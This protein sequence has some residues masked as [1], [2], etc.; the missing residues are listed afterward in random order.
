MRNF[1]GIPEFFHPVSRSA[2][3]DKLQFAMKT[4]PVSLIL[5]GLLAPLCVNAQSPEGSSP[6]PGRDGPGKRQPHRPFMEAWKKADK[7][8]DG[9]LSRGEFDAMPR[10]QSLPEDKR[11]RLF[12]R[13][14]NNKD[15]KLAHGELSRH[16]R[17]PDG[18][19]PPLRRLA[20]LDADK[21][22]GVS[23]EEF[24]TGPLFQ[25]LPAGRQT[26]IFRRLDT[27]GDGVITPKDKPE[28]PMRPDRGPRPGRGEGPPP[29]GPR[30][31]AS[32]MNPERMLQQLDKDGDGAVTFDEFRAGPQAERLSE[33]EQEDRFEA[34]DRNKDL[35]LTPEDF[36]PPP[37]PGR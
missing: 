6:P 35:K 17:Q 27:D 12:E 8:G 34:L 32:R 9:F 33:D 4:I 5:A 22:G 36:P 1:R 11:Q 21:S 2:G 16:D 30:P 37:A 15:G 13:L 25:K 19:R 14:D 3:A 18:P 7:D 23:F 24:K 10:I 28:P 31:E 29:G 26:E 20:E